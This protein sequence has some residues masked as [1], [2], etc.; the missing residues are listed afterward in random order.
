MALI[1]DASSDTLRTFVSANIEPGST[2][3]TDALNSYPII[4]QD[5]FT[6]TAINVKRSGLKAHDVLPGVHDAASLVKSWLGGTLQGGVADENMQSYLDEF[7]FRFNRRHSRQRG[8]LFFRLLE[9]AVQTNPLTY[10]QLVAVPRRRK[11]K[12]APPGKHSWPGTLAVD[13][14]DRP[15]RSS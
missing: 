2:V 11:V 7:V 14:L 10:K 1:P 6:Q 13:P 5:G 15:W 9:Q 3:V 8:L 12:P 4:V